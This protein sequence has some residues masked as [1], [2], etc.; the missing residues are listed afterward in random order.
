M[1]QV[2]TST[3]AELSNYE[4]MHKEWTDAGAKWEEVWAIVQAESRWNQEA[5]NVNTNGS[6][7]R[8]LYQLNSIH[9]INPSCSFDLRCSTHEAIKLWKAQGWTPWVASRKLGL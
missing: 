8:G 4:W 1:A 9:K 6:I 3:P 5:V 7:D 2:V